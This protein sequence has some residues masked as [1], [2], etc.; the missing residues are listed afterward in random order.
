MVVWPEH[1][2][3]IAALLK[4]RCDVSGAEYALFW[5]T[6]TAGLVVGG[7]YVSP[8]HRARSIAEG[9][10][11]T[12][13]EESIAVE[14]KLGGGSAVAR[15]YKSRE[16]IYIE[17]AAGCD[18]FVRR[19]MAK[20][21]GIRSICFARGPQGGVIEFGSRA[22]TWDCAARNNA[23]PE[24][25]IAT[26]LHAG[27]AY[28]IFW[29]VQGAE[30]QIVADYILPEWANA[31]KLERGDDETYVSRSKGVNFFK[32]SASLVASAATFDQLV[33]ERYVSK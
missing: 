12:F 31:L 10:L 22:V 1:S 24:K 13:A 27:A 15:A 3:H 25:E 28:T 18:Y 32:S 16:P 20:K 17:D 21:H 6:D 23:L 2:A 14:L 4:M 9:L 19:D 5:R 7:G 30:F 8:A 11:G 26:G 33:E 29:K